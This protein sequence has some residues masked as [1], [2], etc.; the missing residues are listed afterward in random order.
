MSKNTK[1]FEQTKAFLNTPCKTGRSF[2]AVECDLICETCG[3]NPEEAKRR[4]ETGVMMPALSRFNTEDE[5]EI[6]LPEGV[7]RLVFRPA[8]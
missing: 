7:Q 6:V 5:V 3:W 2:P 4:M 1:S 8:L